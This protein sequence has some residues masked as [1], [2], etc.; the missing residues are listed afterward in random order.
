MKREWRN[1]GSYTSCEEM[2]EVRRREKVS[3][4]KS[5]TSAHGTKVFY[6]CN[7][8]RRTRCNFRMYAIIFTSSKIC[9]FASGEHDHTA[10][11]PYYVSEVI[12]PQIQRDPESTR[13]STAQQD[14]LTQFVMNATSNN[15]LPGADP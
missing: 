3:K 7:N 4:R 8:W 1:Y 2:D 14:I 5:V 12:N 6:R 11:D 13:P 9:L 10:K 15:A